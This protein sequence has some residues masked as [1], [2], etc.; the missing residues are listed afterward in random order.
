[1]FTVTFLGHQGWLFG[2]GP[3]RILVDPLLTEDFGA[4]RVGRVYPPRRLDVASFPAVDAVFFSHEHDDHLAVPTLARLDRR[5]PVYLSC[6]SS[7]AARGVLREMGFSVSLLRPGEAVAVG[8]LEVRAFA[9]DHRASDNLDE[10]DVLPLHVRDRAGHGSF[11]SSIDVDPC[12][13]VDAQV[14]ALG[15]PGLWGATNNAT[16]WSFMK[17]G[18]VLDAGP[19]DTA[20]L[21]A[22]LL[23]RYGAMRADG[24]EP[25]AVLVAGNG[26]SFEG[27]RAWMNANVFAADSERLC[28]VARAAFPGRTFLAPAPG[29]TVRMVDGAVASVDD[30]TP[31]LSALPREAWPVRDYL[32]DVE[33]MEHYAP[34][35][36]ATDLD[37]DDL[38]EVARELDRFAAF[39]YGTALF[40]AL[41]A[42][43]ESALGGRRPT[44][45]VV[46]RASAAGDAFVFEYDPQ[47]CRFARV[48]DR[49]PVG[50]YVS[51]MECWA[52]DLLA[53]ARAT[54]GPFAIPFGRAR[55]WNELPR[56]VNLTALEFCLAYHPLRDPARALALHR[57]LLAAEPADPPRVR[58]AQ[59]P[60]AR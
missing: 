35:C 45:C 1:M 50:D 48:T 2:A 59:A 39:L 4:G 49:D 51:G 13:R 10:W 17:A 27:D 26:F 42:L 21:A 11:F 6:R 36:G 58:A 14:K 44:F 12:A 52:T 53:V 9:P 3:T 30:E 43:D 57:H 41:L 55:F 46:L 19:D 5:I 54:L 20:A 34:A 22:A 31:F 23:A 8:E 47:G 18:E 29:T 28:E 33:L 25:S 32:G 24:R 38:P 40:R 37:P 16:N 15:A 60:A 7:S 56:E